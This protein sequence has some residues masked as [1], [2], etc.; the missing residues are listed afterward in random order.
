M[1]HELVSAL[2]ATLGADQ[3]FDG[4][5][6]GPRYHVDFSH[7]NACVPRAVVKP[8]TTDD[9]AT[10]LRLCNAARQRVVVQ[11]EIGRAHV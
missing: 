1:S 5:G 9:V 7:E 11:G 8:R 4:E 3:V 2:R 6:A 10:T